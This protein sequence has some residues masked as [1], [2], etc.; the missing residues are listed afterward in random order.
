MFDVLINPF[1]HFDKIFFMFDI[2]IVE[3]GINLCLINDENTR[4][5]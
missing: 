2:F 4:K 5:C 3:F 1:Y